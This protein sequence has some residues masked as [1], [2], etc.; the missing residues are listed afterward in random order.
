MS[1]VKNYLL[2]AFGFGI[3]MAAI[4]FFNTDYIFCADK[5]VEIV[6]PLPVPVEVVGQVEIA[7]S[8][9][10]QGEPF[11][12]EKAI[13]II[14]G[15]DRND[16][17]PIFNVPPDKIAVIEYFSGVW[18][19]EDPDNEI[20]AALRTSLN[21]TVVAHWAN[22]SVP[23]LFLSGASQ[24]I[25]GGPVRVYGEPGSIVHGFFV[26]EKTAFGGVIRLNISGRLFDAP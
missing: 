20:A 16:A 25:F 14:A 2:G 4:T 21:G 26:R 18:R 12:A 24:R 17:I 9:G 10:L 23:E 15:Q 6:N 3:V 22:T 11:H 13:S 7:D 8:V 5:E 1:N 19:G